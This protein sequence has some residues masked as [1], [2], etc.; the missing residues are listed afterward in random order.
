MSIDNLNNYVKI[1]KN[2]KDTTNTWYF[3]PYPKSLLKNEILT[4]NISNE[5][6][7]KMYCVEEQNN[8]FDFNVYLKNYIKENNFKCVPSL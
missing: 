7:E 5:E 6:L 8:K 4:D 3:Y 1:T 2:K